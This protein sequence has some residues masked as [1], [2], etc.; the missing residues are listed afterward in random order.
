[1]ADAGPR[2]GRV[3]LLDDAVSSSDAVTSPGSVAAANAV[4]SANGGTPDGAGAYDFGF[5][6]RLSERQVGAVATVHEAFAALAAE[7]LANQTRTRV[8]IVPLSVA[9][10]SSEEFRT[11][12]TSAVVLAGVALDPLAG[13]AV[14]ALDHRFAF[15]L[16]DRLLGGQGVP[17]V[18]SREPSE[19][20]ASVLE[21]RIASLLPDLQSAWQPLVPIRPRVEYCLRHDRTAAA[22]I[23]PGM[24]V[25]VAFATRIGGV[26]GELQLAVPCLALQSIG[27]RARHHPF[28]S[29]PRNTADRHATVRQ[30]LQGVP[31]SV[32]AE[33]GSALLPLPRVLGLKKGDLIRL[34]DR[35]PGDELYLKVAGKPK[36]RCLPGVVGKRFAVQVVKP[37]ELAASLRD[38]ESHGKRYAGIARR[39][40]SSHQLAGSLRDAEGHARSA[41]SDRSTAEAAP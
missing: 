30:A 33:I 29:E 1:M 26:E 27:G 6:A 21:N 15:S 20:E 11:A 19:I 14:L 7:S 4:M 32:S 39:S 36:F 18:P 17:S 41:L 3:S 5:A 23:P 38:A 37:L 8:E 9:Q 40:A 34:D 24:L 10:V 2:R 12:L 13:V 35:G 22:S 28:G 16:I 31:V 25:Q